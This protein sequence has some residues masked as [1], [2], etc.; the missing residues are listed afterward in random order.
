M[1]RIG[2]VTIPHDGA[3]HHLGGL[4]FR[5]VIENGHAT[6]GTWEV[7]SIEW[8]TSSRVNGIWTICRRIS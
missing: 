3:L 7:K 4:L 1:T 6:L 2:C 8:V 5:L